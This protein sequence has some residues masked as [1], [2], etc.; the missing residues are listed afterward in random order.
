MRGELRVVVDQVLVDLVGDHPQPVLHR[1]AADRRDLLRRVDRAGRVGRRH[2]DQDLGARRCGP[3]RAARRSPGSPDVSSVSTAHRHAAGQ[4]DRLGVGG[5]VRRGQEHLVARVEQG[6]EGVVDRLLAA[7]GD[8]HLGGARP[9]SRCPAAS[10][11]RWPRCS[12][13]RPAGGGVAVPPRVVAG[14]DRRLD[15]VVG[16]GEVRLAGAEAD[17]R[18]PGRLQRLGLGVDG[19]RRGLGDGA[20]PQ[21]RRVGRPT[22]A[23][24]GSAHPANPSAPPRRVG[25]R[26]FDRRAAP[27]R[28]LAIL[29]GVRPPMLCACPGP[30]VPVGRGRRRAVAQL[31]RVPVSK[32]GGWGFESLLP[33]ARTRRVRR[34]THDPVPAPR[35]GPT[36]RG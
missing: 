6:G 17:H 22:G 23:A 27:R 33:C 31:V 36:T 11:R 32:T 30:G 16:G 14:R 35:G 25:H 20:D 9:R 15:D 5:P 18:A 8:Q 26:R 4:P 28:T 7:V 34:T 2:E 10:W 12:S 24:E 3:P 1:P 13:G 19:E 21:R 29:G